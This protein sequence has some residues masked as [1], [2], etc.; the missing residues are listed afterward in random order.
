MTVHR[1]EQL[2]WMIGQEH[3]E[4]GFVYLAHEVVLTDPTTNRWCPVRLGAEVSVCGRHASSEPDRR[5]VDVFTSCGDC[6]RRLAL[7]R[8]ARAVPRHVA[9]GISNRFWLSPSGVTA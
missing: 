4:K 1:T 3:A 2:A 9:V 5:A 8:Q 7:S 6:G